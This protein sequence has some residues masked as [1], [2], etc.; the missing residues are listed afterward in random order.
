MCRNIVLLAFTF[1]GGVFA[2]PVD[3][4]GAS[5]SFLL[6][7]VPVSG[8]LTCGLFSF[9]NFSSNILT[10]GL[11]AASYTIQPHRPDGDPTPTEYLVFDVQPSSP[12]SGWSYEV[13]MASQFGWIALSG[14]D[15]PI[16]GSPTVTEH[17][18]KSTPCT[19]D[20][21]LAVGSLTESLTGPPQPGAEN[22]YYG[23][24]Q[25]PPSFIFVQVNSSDITGGTISGL[26]TTFVTPEPLSALL[27]CSGLFLLIASR[28]SRMR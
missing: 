2:G 26:K 14:F 19:Q 12:A 17:F 15:T 28:R 20:N 8:T 25:P 5:Q 9:S 13:G 3:N 22:G 10:G 4:C 24:L 11:V 6:Q 1:L 16:S 18:C 23:V 21:V 27:V 7:P